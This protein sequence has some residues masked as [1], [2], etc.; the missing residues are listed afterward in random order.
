LREKAGFYES[1][2]SE[3]DDDMKQLRCT[4]RKYVLHLIKTYKCVITIVKC[5]IFCVTH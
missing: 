4:A 5:E 2:D 1:D 3:E